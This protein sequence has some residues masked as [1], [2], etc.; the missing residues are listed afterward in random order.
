MNSPV[1]QQWVAFHSFLSIKFKMKSQNL[2]TFVGSWNEILPWKKERIP[3]FTCMD[4]HGAAKIQHIGIVLGIIFQFA[5]CNEHWTIR[6]ADDCIEN[7]FMN[8]SV[9]IQYFEY[10][11]LPVLFIFFFYSFVLCFSFTRT[12]Y[13]NFPYAIRDIVTVHSWNSMYS[14]P[15]MIVNWSAHLCK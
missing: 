12:R 5:M 8:F 6:N 9:W 11:I 13:F 1:C 15:C 2:L 10:N 3:S 14:I 7:H 4:S